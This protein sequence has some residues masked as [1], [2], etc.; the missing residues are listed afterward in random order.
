MGS[1]ISRHSEQPRAPGFD[2]RLPGLALIFV[3]LLL[4]QGAA[5]EVVYLQGSANP[6]FNLRF[7]E[8]LQSELGPDIEIRSFTAVS[9]FDAAPPGPVITLGP[10]A[11]SKVLEA[12]TSRPVLAL[13]VSRDAYQGFMNET[14]TPLSAIFYDPPLLRQVLVGHAVLPQSTRIA[15]LARPEDANRYDELT[16]RLSEIGLEAR[17]FLVTGEDTLIPTL[18]RALSYGDFLLATPDEM[19]YNARTIK[20]ILLTTYRRNR[21][22]IGPGHAFVRAGVL[23]SSFV[24]LPNY[25]AA[26][27]DYVQHWQDTGELPEPTY[28]R[29]FDVELNRQVARS[30]NIPLPDG[31]VIVEEVKRML[32]RMTAEDG[33]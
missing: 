30:L 23:G 25:A 6:T 28:P 5:A 21:L 8:L 9:H 11:L 20:H 24:P 10:E 31:S 12:G 4:A 27:A 13:L 16:A 22:V 19:I 14:D 18:S 2:I 1:S 7:T 26:A 29:D 33:S 3:L 32:E 17:V 15:L